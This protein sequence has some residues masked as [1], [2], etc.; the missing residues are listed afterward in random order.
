MI[1]GESA[2]R[3]TFAPFFFMLEESSIGP[4]IDLSGLDA[5]QRRAI[6][7]A[8]E[9]EAQMKRSLLEYGGYWMVIRGIGHLDF[10][11][12][13]FYSPLRFSGLPFL[14]SLQYSPADP[15]RT[16]RIISRYALAFFNKHV[17]GIEQPLLD[18][19]SSGTP[20]VYLEVWKA[21]A[22]AAHL[23]R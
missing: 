7:F 16:A 17:K 8:R 18:A 11:D 22:P 6:E 5:G 21:K 19:G 13:P 3:G 2:K 10:P 23:G 9:Q 14:P 20:S 4:E 12:F 15:E 1:A